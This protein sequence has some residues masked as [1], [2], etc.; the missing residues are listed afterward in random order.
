VSRRR[1]ALLA[2]LLVLPTL[3]LLS[4]LA[5]SDTPLTDRLLADPL[6]E[7]PVKLWL[8]ETFARVGL[9]G[10]FVDSIGFPH[11]GVLNNPDPGGTLITALLR[12][13]LGRALAYDSLIWLQIFANAAATA[14]LALVVTRDERAAAVAAAAFALTPLALVY[15]VAG[16]VTDVLHLWPWPLAIG[17]TLRA[18][19]GTGG[20]AAVAAGVAAAAGLVLC[21]YNG[22]VFAALAVPGL[23]WLWL[24]RDRPV[25]DGGPALTGRRIVVVGVIISVVAGLPIAAFALWTRS[26]MVA[27]DS[28][29]SLDAVE[30]TRHTAP[31]LDLLPQNADR[32][33]AFLA[34]W[35]AVGKG[36]RIERTLASRFFRA[37][38][39]GLVVL[40]LAVSGLWACRARWRALSLWGLG[41]SF[42]ILASTG[43]FLPLNGGLSL[44]FA[45]NPA[46]LLLHHGLPGASL[47]LEPFRYALP[48]VLC[49]AVLA[50]VG[51]AAITPRLGA[52][53]WLL[54]AV[55][56]GELALVSPVP[57][58]LLTASAATSAELVSLPLP[59]GALLELPWFDRGTDRFERRHFLR[60]L[61][62]GRPIP[63]EVQGFVPPW[64]VDN[65]WT[66]SLIALERSD[67]ARD[68]GAR[69]GGARDDGARDGG[70]LAVVVRWPERVAADLDAFRAAGFAGVWVDPA[71]YA[72]P[73]RATRVADALRD[74]FGEPT[75][76]AG[77][78]LFA[79]E[80][81]AA[82]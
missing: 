3:P 74:A 49:L 20:R 2:W 70:D 43:P 59:P 64:L 28:M 47:L 51:T 33:T 71:G 56:V 34:D 80:P 81:S 66:A 44:P 9:L 22:V 6:G 41:A 12:P 25:L 42:C 30:A 53:S 5:P 37:F 18:L 1:L 40:A 27:P 38:S 60:Q 4:L 39:P 14:W 77:G 78:W 52:W 13:L 31:Y 21:P 63:D 17:A 75:S 68:G 7:I 24:C 62:H 76:A 55:V 79:V 61:D 57:V 48:A 65:Q 50:A 72:D 26:L 8:F 35:V 67:G 15:C 54:P 19:S 16:A 45:G 69:D 82:R 36:A 11:G 46:W 73:A 58:P 23:A 32:Y 29:M 10:G